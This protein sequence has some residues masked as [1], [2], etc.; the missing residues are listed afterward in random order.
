M[1]TPFMKAY[2]ELLVRGLLLHCNMIVQHVKKSTL[3]H[4]ARHDD[5]SLHEGL[6]RSAGK[7]VIVLHHPDSLW[8]NLCS[9]Q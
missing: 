4:M 6:R 1:T 7:S 8:H 9:V 5:H 2:V 3:L